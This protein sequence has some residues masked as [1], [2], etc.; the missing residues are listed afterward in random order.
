[1]SPSPDIPPQLDADWRRLLLPFHAPEPAVTAALTDLA[2]R[3]SEPSRHYH[4]LT[5]LRE[6]LEVI[7]NLGSA[8]PDAPVVRLAAWFHDAVYDSRAKDNEERSADLAEAVLTRLGLPPGLVANVERLV[9]LTKTHSAEPD[10]REGQL[11]LDADLAIL[12]AEESRYDD[13]ARAIRRE[14][15][16]VA[17]DAYRGGR[18]RVLE[19]FLKRPRLYFADALFRSHEERARRNLRRELNWLTG[20]R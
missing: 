11:L 4:N 20:Q 8:D 5:H 13:Y 1:M 18:R 17:E 3:Y 14:Y 2:A 7:S 6:V 16:W 19:A 9:L 10:D 15:A 12:G